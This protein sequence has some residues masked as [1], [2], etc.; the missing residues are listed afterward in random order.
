LSYNPLLIPGI[1]TL[2]PKLF[3]FFLLKTQFDRIRSTVPVQNFSAFNFQH[4][5][6]F[7]DQGDPDDFC[8]LN[9][10]LKGMAHF[11]F[12]SMREFD[13]EIAERIRK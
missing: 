2:E 4:D 10:S 6:A 1:A 3:V 13:A 5:P 7:P 12:P 8:R 11:P 9:D